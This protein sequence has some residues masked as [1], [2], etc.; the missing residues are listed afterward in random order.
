MK[1]LVVAATAAEIEMSMP[2]LQEKQ[3]DCL[4]TGVGMTAT[5]YALGKKLN[6]NQYDIILNV[7][8][9][10][11]LDYTIPIGSVIQIHTDIL[12]ELGAQGPNGFIS[13]D[14]MGFGQ[15]H[16]TPILP[17][18]ISLDL[19]IH[20]GITVNTVHG[21]DS[22]IADVKSL[23]PSA[24]IESMEGAAVCYAAMQE[25]IPCLQVRSISN[26]VEKRDKNKWNIPLALK[27]LNNWLQEFI[28]KHV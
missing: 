17:P 24:S 18:N 4:I 26:R 10:G 21:D 2:L 27:N 23:F 19:P 12:S 22:R 3:I 5:A 28:K 7:G 9:A 20:T 8:I 25:F 15:A 13:I 6:Q 11:T 16:F 14:E 1:L